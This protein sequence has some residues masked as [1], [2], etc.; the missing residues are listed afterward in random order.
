MPSNDLQDKLIN[1]E[2][3]EFVRRLNPMRFNELYKENLKGELP[4]DAIVD[5]E[6]GLKE[7]KTRLEDPVNDRRNRFL[8]DLDP[9]R[10]AELRL[11]NLEGGKHFPDVID[12][13]ISAAAEAK[14]STNFVS[15]VCARCQGM[16]TIIMDKLGAV[17][18]IECPDCKQPEGVTTVTN[19]PIMDYGFTTKAPYSRPETRTHWICRVE[20][21]PDVVK[22]VCHE[23]ETSAMQEAARLCKKTG[24]SAEVVA[25]TKAV[26]AKCEP[27]DVKWISREKS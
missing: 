22:P 21:M 9:K 17:Q 7:T 3:Y 16:G 13:E 8:R 18:T 4:F 10:Y 5:R 23:T 24:K 25:V 6:R 14:A 19:S 27:G 12:R 2:R 15:I 20:G 26:A 11:E 1:A